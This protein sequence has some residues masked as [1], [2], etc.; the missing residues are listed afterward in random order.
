MPSLKFQTLQ[1]G[2]KRQSKRPP[3]SD[4]PRLHTD[5]PGWTGFTFMS[6]SETPKSRLEM[7]SLLLLPPKLSSA[8]GL[9]ALGPRECSSNMSCCHLS[10]N[11]LGWGQ[12]KGIHVNAD[13]RSVRHAKF[14]A[15]CPLCGHFATLEFFLSLNYQQSCSGVFFFWFHLCHILHLCC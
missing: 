15:P 5:T 10:G 14:G 6:E 8:S 7:S 2:P 9:W 12:E 3:V 13:H 1:R 11:S 4:V